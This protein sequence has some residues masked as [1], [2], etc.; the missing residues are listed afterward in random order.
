MTAAEVARRVG[1]S[2]RVLR[3][4][5]EQGLVLPGRRRT[6]NGQSAMEFSEADVERIELLKAYK[7][8]LSAQA[9]PMLHKRRE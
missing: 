2:T 1:L 6:W 9:Q 7:A 3:R 8:E 5:V 4:Y